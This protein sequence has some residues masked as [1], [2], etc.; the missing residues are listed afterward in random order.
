MEA[1]GPEMMTE[2]VYFDVHEDEDVEDETAKERLAA[3][4]EMFPDPKVGVLGAIG[5]AVKEFYLFA[6]NFS[7][8]F[9]IAA[10]IFSGPVVFENE[11]AAR[12]QQIL[13]AIVKQPER[14][15]E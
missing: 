2:T 9:A 13:Q 3:L 6:C 1:E 7:W 8:N 15:S 12:S 4:S 10:M 11:R 5:R 14:K